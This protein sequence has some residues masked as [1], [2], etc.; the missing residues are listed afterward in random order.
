MSWLRV[1]KFRGVLTCEKLLLNLV[2]V[3]HRRCNA[4]HGADHAAK[5]EVDEHEEEHDRPERRPREMSHR[6]REGDKCQAC[7]L[8]SLRHKD[9]GV[10]SGDRVTD[11]TVTEV[12]KCGGFISF[13]TQLKSHLVQLV[14][15][16]TRLQT[17]LSKLVF[18]H[19]LDDPVHLS[20][21]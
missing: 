21:V 6:F 4:R 14:F 1:K 5:T 10:K 11:V 3:E 20:I 16:D 19:G 12:R 9:T 2:C 8:D 18:F 17:Q 7:S 15:Q 13:M